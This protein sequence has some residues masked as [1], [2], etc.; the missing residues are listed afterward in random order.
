MA[1]IDARATALF[2]PAPGNF[3]DMAFWKQ[4]VDLCQ[5]K[6]KIINDLVDHNLACAGG[7]ERQDC[8]PEFKDV[9]KR[10]KIVYD[11][12]LPCFVSLDGPLVKPYFIHFWGPL[13]PLIGRVAR[14]IGV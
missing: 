4:V 13:K 3:Q 2:A 14:D 12:G 7:C 5:W 8:E 6:P 9:P 10:K 11:D 1:L